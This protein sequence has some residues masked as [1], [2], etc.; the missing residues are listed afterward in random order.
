MDRKFGPFTSLGGGKS[1]AG[2]TPGHHFS[3]RRLFRSR[4]EPRWGNLRVWNDGYDSRPSPAFRRIRTRTWRSSP[5]SAKAR[6]THK[7]SLGNMGRTEAGDGPGDVGRHRQSPTPK[8]NMEDEPDDA[9]PDLD[10]AD[11][12]AAGSA[13]RPGARVPS[14]RAIARAGSWT[15]GE[16]LFEADN[17]DALPIRHRCPRRRRH[18]EGRGRRRKNT[19]LGSDRHGLSRP[20]RTGR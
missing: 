5:M 1:T 19:G 10:P 18:A 9:L 2:S 17:N 6:I 7:D 4:T 15:L 12:G 20:R 14:P 13:R 3:F 11:P 8:Y 16:R